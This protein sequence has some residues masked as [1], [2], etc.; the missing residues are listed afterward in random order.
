MCE[1]AKIALSTSVKTIIAV[2]EFHDNI[3][4]IIKLTRDKYYEIE[5][6]LLILCM[7]PLD[8]AMEE[9]FNICGLRREDIHEVILVGGM[10][11]MPIIRE[12]IKNYFN[13]KTPNCSVNPDEVVA[14]GAAIQGYILSHQN[15]PFTDTITLLDIIPL[16]L[17][18]ETYG[19]I[20][21]VIL[22]KNTII[23]ASK[24]KTYS[25][26][27]D[28]VTEIVVKVYEGQRKMTKHNLL[29][30]EFILGGLKPLQRGK[31]EI[32]VTFTVDAN[33]IITVT[34][35]D[36]IDKNKK[37]IT[38]TG[39]KGR[40]KPDEIKKLAEEAKLY[41]ITDKLERNKKKLYF[42]LDSSINNIL[43]NLKCEEN[44]LDNEEKEKIEKS[45]SVYIEWLKEKKYFERSEQEYIDIFK[46]LKRKYGILILFSDKNSKNVTG[47]IN[48]KAT[49]I[50]E[51]D[52][53]EEMKNIF[54]KIE[55]EEIG[56][57]DVDI[58]EIKEIKNILIENC[59]MIQDILSG[60]SFN[61]TEESINL[62]YIIE[63]TLLWSH[64]HQNPKKSDYIEKINMINDLSNSLIKDNQDFFTDYRSALEDICKTIKYSIEANQI[65]LSNLDMNILKN[66]VN[67]SLN[68]LENGG[69]DKNEI[70][71]RLDDVNKLCDSLFDKMMNNSSN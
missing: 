55:K 27:K 5:K 37:E 23:P 29:I 38:I 42:D 21:N 41:E 58:N 51:E 66:K 15:D 65:S 14:M 50:Y 43:I 13:G 10:T 40:L 61:E 33:G 34:A 59:L 45:L 46:I 36:L 3:D 24:T 52:D 8:E 1:N 17:G 2:K 49:T 18:V 62:K 48:D 12:N 22:P 47:K 39:N 31:H 67:E 53:V 7:H 9:A 71:K 28:F 30:G 25:N 57:T 35:E 4:L 11:K 20:M 26:D 16:S 70:C 32:D 56:K 63:D 68:Y 69:K 60:K 19:G 54:E 64:I 6:N 44:K